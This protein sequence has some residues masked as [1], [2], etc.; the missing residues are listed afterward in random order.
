MTLIE[1]I[2]VLG[3]CLIGCLIGALVYERYIR[4][5]DKLIG[6]ALGRAAQRERDRVKSQDQTT[7]GNRAA[8]PN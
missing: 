6:A 4:R 7:A 1:F 5:P 2:V 3:A 8:G